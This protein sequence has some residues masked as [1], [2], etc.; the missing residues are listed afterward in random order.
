MQYRQCTCKVTY[1]S[2][3]VTTGT[4][5]KEKK[6]STYSESVFVALGIRHDNAHAPYCHPKS[7]RLYNIFA[8]DLIKENIFG[9]KN[10]EY[11]FR[12]K[13]CLKHFSS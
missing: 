9:V 1:R 11:K 10:I 7:V 8:H 13:F 4:E 6:I 5:K 2:F 12:Y 3:R